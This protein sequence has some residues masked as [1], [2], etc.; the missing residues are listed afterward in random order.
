MPIDNPDDALQ[1]DWDL[2]PTTR[3]LLEAHARREYP[4]ECCGLI[5]RPKDHPEA[6]LRVRECVN[7]QDIHHRHDPRNFPRTARNA[8]FMDPAD[9]LAVE[10]E[11]R[12]SGEVVAA[13]YHSHCDADPYFSE[14]DVR[15]AVDGNGPIFPGVAYLVMSVREG[16]PIRFKT[17]RWHPEMGRFLSDCGELARA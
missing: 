3:G 14:E 17:F 1:S 12:A 11:R 2:S 9:L 4:N 10:Q 8:Y 15:R 16:L 6:P 7:A 13:I 5:L